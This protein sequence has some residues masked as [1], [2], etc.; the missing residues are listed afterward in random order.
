MESGFSGFDI[1]ALGVIFISGV[2]A[3]TRGFVREALTVTAFVSAALAA[4]WTRPVFAGLALEL[5]SSYLLANALA[6]A[7]T[8]ILVYLAVSF[9]TSSLSKDVKQ[10]EDVNVV[11]RTLGF[12]FGVIR[13]LILLG[14]IVLVFKNTTLAG[15]PSW[16]RSARI[17]PLVD[18][19]AS[20]LQSLAPSGSWAA[21]AH[22]E[23]RQ[24]PPPSNAPENDQGTENTDT[25]LDPDPI[26]SLIQSRSQDDDG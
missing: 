12:I 5:T 7:I 20:L 19:T 26:G 18:A 25:P 11:D 9:V 21:Q 13:G 14:L 16:F 24:T 2:M 17:Y 8:F 6:L 4:L 15:P 10:G 22:T 1:V 23:N 3:L